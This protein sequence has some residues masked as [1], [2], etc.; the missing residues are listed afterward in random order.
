MLAPRTKAEWIEGSMG[1]VRFFLSF[2]WV[3]FS[4]CATY[5][6]GVSA[7][8]GPGPIYIEPVKNSSLCPKA[9][10]TL[11]AQ[12]TKKLQQNTPWKLADEGAA[13]SH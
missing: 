4:G 10:G 12:L 1:S 5:H 11:T 3:S 9:A 8:A 7:G 6:R 13:Q 2:L